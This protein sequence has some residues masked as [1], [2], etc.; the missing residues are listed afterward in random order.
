V[1]STLGQAKPRNT[2]TEKSVESRLKR[3]NAAA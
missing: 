2:R 1:S 3:S